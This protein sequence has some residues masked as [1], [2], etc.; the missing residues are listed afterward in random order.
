MVSYLSLR[1]GILSV[2]SSLL[3]APFAGVQPTNIRAL[4][5]AQVDSQHLRGPG[6][7]GNDRDVLVQRAEAAAKEAA[8][9]SQNQTKKALIAAIA[10]FQKSVRLFRGAHLDGRA[11]DTSLEIGQIYFTLSRYDKALGFYRQ[12]RNLDRK[13]PETFCLV[14]SYMARTYATTGQKSQAYAASKQ[15]LG[16]CNAL[17]N[18][19]MQAEALEARGEA[20]WYSEGSL[21]SAEFFSR[22]QELFEKTNDPGRQAHALIML[23]YAHTWDDP[24]GALQFAGKALQLAMAHNDRHGIAEARTELGFFAAVQGEF[25]TAKCNYELALPAFRSIGDIDNEAVALNG[26]GQANW[27]S[28]NLDRSLEHYTRAKA[29]FSSVR[30]DIGAVEAIREMGKSLNALRRYRELVALYSAELYLA[31]HNK[32]VVQKADA[33]ADMAGVYELQGNT[34]KAKKLYE[35]ALNIHSSAKNDNGVAETLLH[36]AL[37]RAR[38]GADDEALGLLERARALKERSKQ[39]G[40]VARID[41]EAANIYRRLNRL[42]DA[43]SSI[44]KTIHAIEFQR[45][46]IADFDSRANYFSSV[47]K[48]YALYIQ[49]LMRLDRQMPRPGFEQQAFEASEKSKVRSLLDQLN[50]SRQDSSCKEL[51]E[52][53]LHQAEVTQA[54]A[55]DIEGEVPVPPVLGLKQIQAELGTGDTVLE[56]LLGDE[57]SYLWL[58]NSKQIAVRELPQAAKIEMQARLFHDA[59]TAREPLAGDDLREYKE[60]IRAADHDYPRL[61]RQLS[62]M[63][64]GPVDLTGATRLLIVPDGFLQNV[65]FSALTVSQSGK[66]MPLISGHEVVVLPSASVLAALRKITLKRAAPTQTAA[67]VADPVVDGDDPR[68]HPRTSSRKKPQGGSKMKTRNVLTLRHVTR[69]EG[70]SNEA[71]T[72]KQIL[73]SPDV[74]VKLGFNANRNDV[75]QGMLAPYRIIHFATH[76]LVNTRHPEISGLVLS[77][78]NEKGQR[79]DGFLRSGDIANLKLSADLVVLSACDSALGKNLASEGTIGLPRAFLFAGSR[80]VLASLWKVDDEAAV[81][82]M[83]YFYTRIQKHESPGAALRGAQL[84]MFN[85]KKW[86]EPFYWATFV[87]Q[88]DYR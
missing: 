9:L 68:L 30:D 36:L 2:F 72:I 43:R 69:L 87:L 78:R 58:V 63:L 85:G 64:L 77:L 22:A 86:T 75:V 56:F 18:L 26:V 67:I 65:P 88:G 76:G 15:A 42:R 25:E 27:Q 70:S 14:L 1:A 74:L 55:G 7:G 54:Q 66:N 44:E 83:K 61:A 39:I 45:L 28:G 73:D 11:A 84:D 81:T 57:K 71:E 82:F 16:Q 40:D 80:S 51:L 23:A 29:A 41:Y 37:L 79:Q 13:N 5:P 12:A 8:S 59:L 10:L 38:Q 21:R 3:F 47:H 33:L 35:D 53:Q 19:R 48:Y 20:L 49:I 6:K 52:R 31:Q 34:A 60:R 62:Q 46:N 4:A 50:A 32:N 24:S 17:P